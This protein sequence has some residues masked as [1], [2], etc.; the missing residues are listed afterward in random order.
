MI[1]RL[2]KIAI[3]LF[4]AGTVACIDLSAPKDEPASISLVQVPEGFIVRGDAMRDS[5]GRIVPPTV[6]AYDANGFPVG[7]FKAS[8]FVTDTI[9]VFR[10]ASDGSLVAGNKTGVGH[11]I[12]QIGGVQTPSLQIFVTVEPKALVKL[13]TGSDTLL[14]VLNTD[15]AKAIARFNMSVAVRGGTGAPTDSGVG[16]AF[17]TY[18]L[19]PPALPSTRPSATVAYVSD[20]SNVPVT[21]DTT[22]ANGVSSKRSLVV[23]SSTLAD[24]ALLSG[25]KVATLT[26]EASMSYRGVPL[27]GSPQ[28]FVIKLKSPFAK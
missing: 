26:V 1:A 8:F 3:G 9:P 6:I 10:L 21:I 22:D 7:D 14:L 17:I 11:I 25:S 19:L 24:T 23:N 16:G 15:S 5:L 20:A 4:A 13:T 12:G 2:A 28:R 27:L 18:R